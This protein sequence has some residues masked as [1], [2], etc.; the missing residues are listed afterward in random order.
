MGQCSAK[1]VTETDIFYETAVSLE[2]VRSRSSNAAVTTSR[3]HSTL[4]DSRRL[5]DDY[6]V[7]DK[8]LGQGLC[9]DVMLIHGKIDRRRY[10]LKTFQKQK[11]PKNKLQLLTAEVE[12]YLTL[13]HPNIARLHDV[14]ESDTHIFLVTECCDGGELYF[15]LQKRGTYTDLDAAQASREMLRA[16]G[17]LHSH[18]VVHRDLK[19]ENFLYQGEEDNTSLKLIDFGFAKIWDSSTLMMASCGSVAY[20]SP[21][22]LSGKGYTNKCDL[23]SLGIIVW[24]LLTGYPPFHGEEAAMRRKIR[25][26]E[27]DWKHKS[28][29]ANVAEDAIDFV[30][31]LLVKDPVKRLSAAEALSHPWLVRTGAEMS[32]GLGPQSP[33]SRDSLRNLKRYA[34]ASKVRRAVLQLLAQELSSDETKELREAFLAIDKSNS[35]TISL[36]DLKDAVRGGHQRRKER[37]E[38][39]FHTGCEPASPQIDEPSSPM[40]PVSPLTP[41]RRLRRADSGELQELFSRLDANGDEQ[42]YYTDFLAATATSR[43]QLRKEVVNAVFHRLD[44]DNSGAITVQDFRAVLG[45]QFEGVDVEELVREADPSGAGGIDFDTFVRVLEDHDAVP[46]LTPSSNRSLEVRTPNRKCF[47]MLSEGFDSPIVLDAAPVSR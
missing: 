17:Y 40:S 13:D 1:A 30:K 23:W 9:G 44:A 14:Y 22:V 27:A 12:I 2:R 21:D 37:A 24:M 46:V 33:L 32:E 47:G 11:V 35:G 29:W 4:S 42:I 3:Y 45:D 28:R 8:S 19:L 6:E 26:A 20:V 15:R 10:A 25:A 31:A 34:D 39:F 7:S 16:V 5:V 38:P 43:S 41:A 18:D 36:R